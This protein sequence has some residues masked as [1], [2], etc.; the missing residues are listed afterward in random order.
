MLE[1]LCDAHYSIVP[2]CA[3]LIHIEDEDANACLFRV[4]VERAKIP[5][6]VFVSPI[7]SSQWLFLTD[8]ES[9]TWLAARGHSARHQ[10]AQDGWLGVLTSVKERYDLRTIPVVVLS[11]SS[12][13]D[14]QI[15][16]LLLGAVA[17]SSSRR[18]REIGRARIVHLCR[19]PT[20]PRQPINGDF[21]P[22][23]QLSHA[24]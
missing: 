15:R 13:S 12:Q 10:Y 22:P 5:V 17:T 19:I 11:T 24:R 20:P 3:P 18:F 9:T 14:D 4:A 21:S 8:L 1:S 7:A 23:F 16:A 2:T 6:R